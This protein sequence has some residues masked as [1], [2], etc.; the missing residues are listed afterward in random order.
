LRE[1]LPDYMVP[2][3]FVTLAALPLTPN[4]KVDREALPDP[5]A[6]AA[7]GYLAPRNAAEQLMTEIWAETLSL[8]RVGV[9][10]DFFDLGGH[11]LLASRLLVR[12]G[13]RWGVSLP[14]RSI[15]DAPTPARLTEMIEAVKWAAQA[16]LAPQPATSN[17]EEGAL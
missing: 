4:G 16:R 14:L 5:A 10:D 2:Q 12:V 13:T 3:H 6:P 1:R 11:S 17:L 15:F 8:E 7:E 9:E